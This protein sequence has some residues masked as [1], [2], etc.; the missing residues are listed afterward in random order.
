MVV[1]LLV[2]LT[3]E[4]RSNIY[5]CF[6]NELSFHREL[7]PHSLTHRLFNNYTQINTTDMERQKTKLE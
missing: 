5:R 6:S 7:C 3:S 1:L 4:E 2:I